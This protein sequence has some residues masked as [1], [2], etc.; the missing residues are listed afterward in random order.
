MPPPS[1]PLAFLAAASTGL[2]ACGGAWI[3]ARSAAAAD[4]NAD[5]V[6]AAVHFGVLATLAM[7]VLGAAHQFTPVITGRPLR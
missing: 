4:P 6:V 5:P 3:W 7:G 2:V 1:V